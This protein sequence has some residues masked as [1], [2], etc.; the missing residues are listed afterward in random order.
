MSHFKRFTDTAPH[1][2]LAQL[3]QKALY[4]SHT[5]DGMP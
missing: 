2:S 4:T 1:H 3:D 5:T